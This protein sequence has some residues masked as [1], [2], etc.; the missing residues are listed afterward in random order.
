MHLEEQQAHGLQRLGGADQHKGIV[1]LG[2]HRQHIHAR[3]AARSH[4]R[5]DLPQQSRQTLEN[6]EGP[7]GW[8]TGIKAYAHTHTAED[9]LT[10]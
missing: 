4:Q 5:V 2:V 7:T 6:R 10:T 8:G 1:A 9:A 3:E